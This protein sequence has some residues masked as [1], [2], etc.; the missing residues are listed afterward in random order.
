LKN[1]LYNCLILVL[2]LAVCE[3]AATVVKFASDSYKQHRLDRQTAWAVAFD[4]SELAEFSKEQ[5]RA[6]RLTWTS[7]SYW[8]RAP[9]SGR[10]VNVDA[11]GLRRTWNPAA[12]SS[13]RIRIFTFGGST[14]WGT[15][16]RDDYTIPSQL[17][18]ALAG[19]FGSAVEVV[20]F[21]EAGYV[22]TQEL[23]ALLREIQRGN[24]PSVAVFYD[25]FNDT[26]SAFQNG[27][28]GLPQNERNR[29]AE[30][31]L[32]QS[33]PRFYLEW[34]RQSSLFWLLSGFA[35]RLPRIS[36]FA[37]RSRPTD[38]ALAQDEGRRL[39]SDLLSVY[40]TNVRVL[41]SVGMEYH[42]R[43]FHYWQPSV[44]TKANQTPEERALADSDPRFER[45]HG[46]A[47]ARLKDS[48]IEK[49]GSFRDLTAAFDGHPERIFIDTMHPSERGNERVAG[50]IAADVADAVRQLLQ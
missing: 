28:A 8:R 17:S 50:M 9:V 39:I 36:Y 38:A 30:F 14:M 37:H 4:R 6:M 21:G 16:S 48:P 7:Y 26:F 13:P 18:K 11:N 46:A 44:Y 40:D 12:L 41:N 45:F 10:Y 22:Q 29:V 43:M 2:L 20:N 32:L 27:A 19:S 33:G 49:I 31:N 42:I 47:I 23:I 5:E 35:E 34:V 1:V 24:V 3:T 15:G 25:G